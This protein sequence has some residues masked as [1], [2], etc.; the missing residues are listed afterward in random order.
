MYV[1]SNHGYKKNVPDAEEEKL[2][3]EAVMPEIA[4]RLT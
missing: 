4:D 3:V 1:F 2:E